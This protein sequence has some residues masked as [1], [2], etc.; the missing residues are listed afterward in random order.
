MTPDEARRDAALRRSQLRQLS[1]TLPKT[2]T[3]GHPLFPLCSGLSRDWPK[4]LPAQSNNVSS[5][6]RGRFG[7]LPGNP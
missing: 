5:V 1:L 2:F 7:S 4:R 6:G 3:K